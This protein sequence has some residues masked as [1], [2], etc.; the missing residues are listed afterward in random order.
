[1]WLLGYRPDMADRRPTHP[2]WVAAGILLVAAGAVME[3]PL[4]ISAIRGNFS[5][6]DNVAIQ[7]ALALGYVVLAGGYWS[8]L[9]ATLRLGDR[10][11]VMVRPLQIFAIANLLFAGAFLID[12]WMNLHQELGHPFYG[13]TPVVWTTSRILT[14]LGFAVA[15]IALWT[16]AR[17]LGRAPATADEPVGADVAA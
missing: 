15:S 4:F 12:S 8:W 17:A 6:R 5:I 3:I 1:M 16:S 11:A 9:A 10:S 14:F 13:W 2:N 7:L